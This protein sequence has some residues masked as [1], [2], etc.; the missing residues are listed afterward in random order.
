MLKKIIPAVLIA[1]CSL[2]APVVSFA[3]ESESAVTPPKQS[4]FDAVRITIDEVVEA[5]QK[6]KGDANKE[7]RRA[8]LRKIINPRFDFREMAM[9]SLGANWAVATP[10]E[11]IEFVDV[12]S[13]LLARTYLSKIETVEP[14]MVKVDKEKVEMPR[15]LVKSIVTS[16]GDT[17]P[18][19]YKLVVKEND[20]K[21]YDVIIENIGLVANY[22]S[23][24]AGIVRKDKISGLIEKLKEKAAK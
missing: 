18:I 19:D 15:A 12:F 11:Q 7:A 10:E 14:G 23:E 16:N 21:V 2:T 5:C 3:Q 17:F 13:D 24:F 1:V 9:R 20:W 22:R 8:E 4:A 6:Y